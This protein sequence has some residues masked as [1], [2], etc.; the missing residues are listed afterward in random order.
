MPRYSFLCPLGQEAQSFTWRLSLNRSVLRNENNNR[1][2]TTNESASCSRSWMF[3]KPW[4]NINLLSLSIQSAALTSC[5]F[6]LVWLFVNEVVYMDCTPTV[7]WFLSEGVCMDRM[8]VTVLARFLP[9][10]FLLIFTLIDSLHFK[11]P[12]H[13]LGHD[14]RLDA[15]KWSESCGGSRCER[16]VWCFRWLCCI[17]RMSRSLIQMNLK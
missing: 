12:S 15:S 3:L 4:E 10:C 7:S 1:K 2:R 16:T 6:T 8:L 13:A 9:F 11:K 5:S 17:Y 14:V